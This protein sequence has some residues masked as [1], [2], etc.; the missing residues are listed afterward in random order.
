MRNILQSVMDI[1]LIKSE[2]AKL[3]QIVYSWDDTTEVS[4]IERDLALDK[5]KHIYELMRFGEVST[6]GTSDES[7][8]AVVAAAISE[9]PTKGGDKD[10]EVEFLFDDEEELTIA[11][12]NSEQSDEQDMEIEVLFA[13]DEDTASD[14]DED[15][16]EDEG[17]NPAVAEENPSAAE[18][19]QVEEDIP[20]A[21]PDIEYSNSQSN[22]QI[23]EEKVE[24]SITKENKAEEN[25]TTKTEAQATMPFTGN[26]FGMEEP[27]R[28]T[29][30]KHLRM[31]SIYDDADSPKQQEKSV[32][33]SKIFDFSV[34][35]NTAEATPMTSSKETIV[36]KPS[37]NIV[38][39]EKGSILAESIAVNK[40]T[41]A[42][43]I[44]A[45]APL[46]EEITNSKITSLT[47]GV[48]IND[49]FLMIRDLFDGDDEAYAAA[50]RDLDAEETFEDCMIYIV[51]HFEWNP[52]SD[53]AKFMMKLLERKHA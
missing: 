20:Q 53:G 51:E 16:Y 22:T 5:V 21:T 11:T 52:D 30:S 35:M 23:E 10:V 39:E 28:P 2:I 7:V 17:P 1:K 13:E 44:S 45:P 38:K 34:E 37:T 29:R 41:L 50:I 3:S 40:Q 12:D 46:A 4:G 8:T 19:G 24:D 15:G 18:E 9:I 48:G 25:A 14:E 49:K 43:T 6:P 33:I 31:M 47:D 32:D 27:K 42:D 36:K 26:L